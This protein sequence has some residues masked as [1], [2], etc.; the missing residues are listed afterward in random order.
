MYMTTRSKQSRESNADNVLSQTE[1]KMLRVLS[2]H[3]GIMTVSELISVG[4]GTGVRRTTL[5]QRL[6]NSPIISRSANGLYGLIE[7]GENLGNRPI[8]RKQRSHAA[9][10]KS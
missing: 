9:L 1:K 6:F 7:S 10:R 4:L 5:Y 3:G 8:H 2:E